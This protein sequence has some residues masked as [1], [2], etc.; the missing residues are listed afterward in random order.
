MKMTCLGMLLI[1]LVKKF[2]L[3]CGLIEEGLS[4]D[5]FFPNQGR[6][7][8]FPLTFFEQGVELLMNLEDFHFEHQI[9]SYE[10]LLFHDLDPDAELFSFSVQEYPDYFE[11]EISESERVN[12]FYGGAVLFHKGNLYLLNPKQISLLKEL[13]ELPQEE[14]GRKCLQFD[15]SDRDRLAACL[16]L[17]GQLGT[18]SAPERLQIRS[19]SPIFYFDREDDG[20]IRLDIEFDYG[21]LKVTSQQ[22]LEQL[23]FSSDAVLE[24]QL[25]QVCLGAGFEADFQSWR[26]AL[27]PEAVYSFFHH[28]IPALRN[29]VRFSCLMK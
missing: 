20:R 21:D 14:R 16:P 18:V 7:L 23:P 3:L 8:F 9:T 25:F 27:K 19:F 29:W 6:H 11:M 26:Q 22:Q 28:T 12:V 17:F 2:L 13:K 1:Q 10:N 24:N 15:N 4:Q 5:L